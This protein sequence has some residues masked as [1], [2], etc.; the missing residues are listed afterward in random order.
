[1]PD[2]TM[3]TTLGLPDPRNEKWR[4]YLRAEMGRALHARCYKDGYES[5]AWDELPSWE[6]DEY[7]LQ[8]QNIIEYPVARTMMEANAK[9]SE[10][11]AIANAEVARS[12]DERSEGRR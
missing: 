6:Q 1:V 4:E 8:A 11:L 9:L 2:T 3:Y 5:Y 12:R 10:Q 7:A